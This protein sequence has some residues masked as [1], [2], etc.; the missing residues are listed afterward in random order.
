VNDPVE[1]PVAERQEAE[2]Q[3]RPA[4]RAPRASSAAARRSART[5][6]A[7][8]TPAALDIP[9]VNLV[10]R[11]RVALAV[12]VAAVGSF[13]PGLT[14]GQSALFLI[15]G[16]VW[17]PWS[18]VVLLASA[19]PNSRLALIGGP[20]G[21]LVV[22]FGIQ[23]AV[24]GAAAAVLLGDV[25]V[26]AFGAYT[27]G[28][29]AAAGFAALAFACTVTSQVAAPGT[30]RLGA[31]ALIPF[32]AAALAIVFLVERTSTLRA[33]ATV[34]AQ[35][36]RTRAETVLAH[37]AD[38]VVVTD[39]R[40][41]VLECNPSACTLMGGPAERIVGRPCR[42]ALGL[43]SEQ[44]ELDCTYGC[45]M[46][47]LSAGTDPMLGVELW[48]H[49]AGG[50]RQPLLAN[51]V[52]VPS[53]GGGTDV[54]HSLRDV[55]RLKQAEEAKTL[56]LATASHELKTPLT[57]IRGFADLLED[58][59]SLD[60]E[61]RNEALAAIS[62]RAEQ[63]TQIVERLLLSSRIE[64]GAVTVVVD[65][66]DAGPIVAVRSRAMATATGRVI[67]VRVPDDLPRVVGNDN[68]I[69]T[70][71][72]HLLDNALK[73]SPDGAP[74]D[75]DAL[76]DPV[77][78]TVVVTD[79]GIG[80]DSAQAAQ[81]F[82]KFWQAESTDVRRFGGTGIGLYIV[83]SL[84]EAMGGGV[85]VTSERGLGSHFMFVLRRA[86]APPTDATPAAGSDTG[87]VRTGM[88][89]ETSIREFMRQIG[90]PGRRP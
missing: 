85:G 47:R 73:Y 60:P 25:V 1:R 75:V 64:S 32:C 28:R 26:I 58:F 33:Q 18:T 27:A 66:V 63:L 54:V 14:R 24:P 30:H 13:L 62:A 46:L 45:E 20:V 70:V 68:A 42:E 39:D 87:T 71:I 5:E 53:D 78:V 36:Y 52:A 35:R 23:V 80:M 50:L 65:E 49:D 84:V 48:R 4:E 56:F 37:V 77:S 82:E 11:I 69:V 8:P 22:L 90:I 59:D 79:R 86:D 17:V 51:A 61:A 76:A 12:V 57:V 88:G 43:W 9:A 15:F 2:R 31:W 89:E 16:L 74:V 19:R 29:R 41:R 3:A 40:G 7:T 55:T 10:A 67:T 21:D 38:A 83:R 72:D 34:R 6:R 81:C 44:R